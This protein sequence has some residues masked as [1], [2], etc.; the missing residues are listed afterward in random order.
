MKIGHPKNFWG[1][2]LFAFIGGMFALVAKGVPGVSIMAGYS[3]GTPARMGPAFFPFWLGVILFALGLIIAISGFRGPVGRVAAPDSF[4]P[5]GDAA[6]LVLVSEEEV[7]RAA[8]ELTR[9]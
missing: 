6:E 1:G 2:V 3:M 4:V 5:L 9:T 7:V 8:V